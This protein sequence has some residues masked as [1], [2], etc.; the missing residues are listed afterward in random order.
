MGF[1]GENQNWEQLIRK[2]AQ[3]AENIENLPPALAL[4]SPNPEYPWPREAPETAPAE[5]QFEIW[6]ELND[7]AAGEVCQADPKSLRRCRYLHL[8]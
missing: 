8:R 3:L 7:T 2:S 5:H 1:E 4:D 6:L